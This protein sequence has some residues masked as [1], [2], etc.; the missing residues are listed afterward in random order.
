MK[1]TGYLVKPRAA[2]RR[3]SRDGRK[4][5]SRGRSPAPRSTCFRRAACRSIIRFRKLDNHRATPHLGYV[6]EERSSQP[7][8]PDG[9]RA[10]TLVQGRAAA[11]IGVDLRLTEIETNGRATRALRDDVCTGPVGLTHRHGAGSGG[12]TRGRGARPPDICAGAGAA[13]AVRAGCAEAVA[14]PRRAAGIT[15]TRV[16]TLTRSNRSGDILVQ[17]PMQP[18][19]RICRSSRSWLVTWRRRRVERDK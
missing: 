16:A 2:D 19:E 14:F 4:A 15:T 10:S 7:L 12:T 6:T 3:R 5:C 8:R 11:K 13:P 1:Q 17:Q 18:D 9:S